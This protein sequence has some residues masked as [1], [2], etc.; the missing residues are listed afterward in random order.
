MRWAQVFCTVLHIKLCF[1]KWAHSEPFK[2]P[3]RAPTKSEEV[4][5]PNQ[6]LSKPSLFLR[7]KSQILQSS[8]VRQNQNHQSSK[9]KMSNSRLRNTIFFVLPFFCHRFTF[10]SLCTSWSNS[11]FALNRWLKQ[12]DTETHKERREICADCGWPPPSDH[13][14]PKRAHVWFLLDVNP[15]NLTVFIICFFK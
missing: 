2:Q 1:I 7:P 3:Y 12:E 14:V 4:K 10:T 6:I 9:L 13:A 15:A 11:R 8:P 5:T